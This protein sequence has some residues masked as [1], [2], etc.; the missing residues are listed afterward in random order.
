MTDEVHPRTWWP[1][2]R[3]SLAY[4]WPHR[5]PLLIGLVAALGVSVFYTFSLSSTIPLL[6]LIFADHET[7]VDWMHRTDT[8]RRLDAVIAADMPDNPAGLVI[9]HVR[10]DSRSYGRLKDGDRITAIGGERLSSYKLM[11]RLAEHADKALADVVVVD[12]EGNTRTI[13]LKLRAYHNW[14]RLLSGVASVLPAGK[15]AQSRLITLAFVMGALVAVAILGAICRIVNQ[16]LIAAAVQ[17]AMHDLRTKMAD[18]VLRLPLSWHSE[19]PPGDTLGRF[20]TDLSKIEVGITTLFGKTISE[21][22]KAVGV[23]T[24]TLM[25][26]YKL[27]LV[28]LIGLP[29]GGLVMRAFGRTVKR[30]Q[31]RASQSWGRLLDHL[32]EKLAGIR[33]VKAYRMEAAEARAF[34]HEGRTL[35]RAQTHIEVVDAA[36]NPALETLAVIGV[37]AFILYGGGRVFNQELEPHLFFA[38]VVCMGGIFDPVRKMGNVNNRLQ[39]A[40]VSARR[41]FELMDQPTEEQLALVSHAAAGTQAPPGRSRGAAASAFPPLRP[42]RE[43]IEFRDLWFSYPLHPDRPV[44]SGIDVTVEKGQVVALVGPNGSGKT[45]LMS[46]LLRFFE[47]DRGQI[48]IDGQDIARVSLD[49]LRA[50]IGLVTQ[51]SVVFSGSVREN[52]AYCPDSEAQ[53]D[54]LVRRAAQLAHI[55]DFVQKLTSRA[56]GAQRDGYDALVTARTLSGGQRQ[57]IALA[58]AILGDPPILVLDEATS[59]IDSESERRIQEAMEDLIRGRTVFIIAHRF[60]TIAHAD[61]TLVLNEGRL[62]SYGR[63]AD[64]LETC[65]F[66]VKLCETQF[67]QG[68]V[69]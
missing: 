43:R 9:D 20:A 21:P 55:D 38:A 34:E 15:D 23:L 61:L 13:E 65:P 69:I 6:K 32:G 36:T 46:L 35:T 64:L 17:Q 62:V 53:S 47:P 30:A 16:G 66:Y 39:Q 48:L 33:V 28:A 12:E 52:I 22:L 18:H 44:L 41:V 54:A 19:H 7:L 5:R 10:P 58:R 29:V 31:K 3:R 14:S 56:N 26:D 59:Q 1:Y 42:F 57:R 2:F 24:L 49:S 37:A 45:T 40:D 67:T 63:H 60:S 8:Q 25:I 4:L 11:R 51:D 50:Q 68:V 27:L